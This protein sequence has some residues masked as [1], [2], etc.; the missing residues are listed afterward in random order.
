[1]DT[2]KKLAALEESTKKQIGSI[3]EL[4]RH[5]IE[6]TIKQ[7]ELEIEK[8][9]LLA[10]QAQQEWE[11]IERIN[12]SD[13]AYMNEWRKSAIQKFQEEKPLRDNKIYEQFVKSLES[14]KVELVKYKKNLK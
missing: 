12:N 7:V 6:A 2:D 14:I 8:N 4:A 11:G 9:Q 13:V 10:R 1:M 3:K 5:Q